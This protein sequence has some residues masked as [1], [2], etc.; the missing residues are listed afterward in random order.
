MKPLILLPL[1]TALQE[2]SDSASR[3][4]GLVSGL[5]NQTSTVATEKQ[6]EK[7]RCLNTLNSCRNPRYVQ[8]ISNHYK[9]MNYV[10]TSPKFDAFEPFKIP[11]T[12]QLEFKDSFGYPISPISIKGEQLS[13]QLGGF[14]LANH[15]HKGLTSTDF[16][17]STKAF[18]TTH[19]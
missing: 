10:K 11:N 19:N 6:H 4:Y 15:F 12:K 16:K 2:I 5:K 9:S 8:I 17:I 7:K 3:E 14:S 18:Q 13:T 1:R